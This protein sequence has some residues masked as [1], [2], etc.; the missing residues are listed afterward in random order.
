MIF[1]QIDWCN[2]GYLY[3]DDLIDKCVPC[4]IGFYR[5]NNDMKCIQCP[6]GQTT[7]TDTA[8]SAAACQGI[9]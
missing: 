4:G 9:V 7:Y 8:T 6:N 3:V 5:T 2:P 1:F